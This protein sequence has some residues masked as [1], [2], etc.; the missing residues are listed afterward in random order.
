MIAHHE[1]KLVQPEVKTCKDSED[2]MLRQKLEARKKKKQALQKRK[3]QEEVNE[4]ALAGGDAEAEVKKRVK[5]AALQ[6]LQQ[7][8][9]TGDLQGAVR[10]LRQA[11][12]K[13]V[14]E[15]RTAHSRELASKMAGLPDGADAADA[16]R[17]IQAQH[18]AEL[19]N[20]ATHQQ[21]EL[22]AL[23]MGT[24][25]E[26]ESAEAEAAKLQAEKEEK[27]KKIT[28][29]AEKLKAKYAE[30]LQQMEAE[31]EEQMQRERELFDAKRK[32][33]GT[34]AMQRRQKMAEE[35]MALSVHEE[36]GEQTKEQILEQHESDKAA[37]LTSLREQEALQ[38]AEL[39][40]KL[41]ERK[42]SIDARRHK[43]IQ[44]KFQEDVQFRGIQQHL[45]DL[46]RAGLSADERQA[47]L[48]AVMVTKLQTLSAQ[49]K[50][51]VTTKYAN[52]WLK[53][54]HGREL[55]TP[56]RV[57]T[58]RVASAYDK[59]LSARDKGGP[60]VSPLGR[61]RVRHL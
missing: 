57:A 19:A 48:S 7:M 49:K 18:E 33:L 16:E 24:A 13:E 9:L 52:R 58:P 15:L 12:E 54:V 22:K 38:S 35:E 32:E 21:R 37:Y 44:E 23:E 3:Q 30:E 6:E 55:S 1:E 26:D 42:I 28:Q 17:S 47:V 20:L 31:L 36:T 53:K 5:A 43:E 40:R 25:V 11:H 8:V 45:E 2:D 27:M 34:R 46:D 4:A 41:A 60:P 61:M 10:L 29:D 14:S 50:M 39:Q 56:A 51:D 59:V